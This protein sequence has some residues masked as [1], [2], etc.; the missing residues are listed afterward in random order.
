MGDDFSKL[1]KLHFQ[2]RFSQLP[3]LRLNLVSRFR[4]QGLGNGCWLDFAMRYSYRYK[5][6]PYK[7]CSWNIE[8]NNLM[9]SW[10]TLWPHRTSC[11]SSR[12]SCGIGTCNNST[13][14]IGNC[15]T[16][17]VCSWYLDF[18]PCITT[19]VVSD[20]IWHNDSTYVG[21]GLYESITHHF[22]GT[23]DARLL[24][25]FALGL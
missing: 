3:V 8:W 11:S 18:S 5:Q 14:F 25:A 12:C 4:L 13:V 20:W 19:P 16:S 1:V 24:Q 6:A 17:Q 15:K 10:R 23:N 2:F 7:Q 22:V 21:C 9:F